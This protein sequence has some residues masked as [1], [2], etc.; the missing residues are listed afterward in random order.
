MQKPH[1][2]NEFLREKPTPGNRE[3][4]YAAL[5]KLTCFTLIFLGLWVSTQRFAFLMGYNP[6][7]L[8]YPFY[9]LESGYPLYYPWMFLDWLLSYAFKPDIWPVLKRACIPWVCISA[10]AIIFYTFLTYLRGFKQSSE[11]V[12]GTARWATKDDLK[13]E[14]LLT[15][16]PGIV[17]GQLFD[18]KVLATLD[19]EKGAVS[20]H[21]I[22]SSLLITQIGIAN[23]LLAAPTRSG[24]GVSTVVTTCLAYRWS[25]FVLDFKGENFN[26]TSGFRSQFSDVYRYAPI[27]EVGHGFNFLMEIR[28]GKDAYGDANLIA[29][30]LMTPQAGKQNSDANT[31]HFRETGLELLTAVVLHCLCSDYQNKSLPGVK[32]FLSQ[33]NPEDPTDDTY[34]Y[35]LM[36][37][38]IHC[39]NEIHQRV[40]NAASNQLKRPDR[41]RGSVLS[42]VQKALRVFEDTRVRDSSLSH[43]FNLDYFEKSDRPVSLYLTLPY[44]HTSRLSPLLRLF[45][46]ILIRKFSDGETQHDNRKLKNPLL[47]I[48]DEFDKLGKFPE[49]QEAMGILNGFGVHFLLIVQSISQLREIYGQNHQ[50]FAHCKNVVFYAPGE[51]ESGKMASEIIGKDSVW[52]SNTST[53]GSRFSVSLDNLNI[54]GSEMARD[55]INPDEVLKLPLDQFIMI[56]QGKPPY[57]G[58]KCVYYEDQ[59]FNMRVMAP[60]FSTRNEAEKLI[61]KNTQSEWWQIPLHAYLESTDD[62]V[63]DK[64]LIDQ[65][66]IAKA[67]NGEV[68]DIPPEDFFTTEDDGNYAEL[69]GL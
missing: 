61:R 39:N 67:N 45:I 10:F 26:K 57:I 46:S 34:I 37:N 68:K 12:F 1:K 20:L 24:K 28:S 18:A 55:I 7:Y 51:I 64:N 62:M 54:S 44:A 35:L 14:G 56:T 43:E 6:H 22:E 66:L 63:I 58:K 48:L 9:I 2:K 50:F 21:L 4:L 42:T 69:I 8:K 52:K 53:S 38:G 30:T 19:A 41:E 11:N 49:L 15:E 59:R 47:V 16:S 31:E 40:V 36:M 60:A 33:T 27:S 23:G 29:D 5:N 3:Q 13:D 65:R 25:I 32:D 17:Y